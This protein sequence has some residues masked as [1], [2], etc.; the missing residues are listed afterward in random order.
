RDKDISGLCEI[1]APLAGRIVL[2][3]VKSERTALP[4]DL[5]A[6]CRRG[7]PSAALEA[8]S[9]LAEALGRVADESLILI[10][11]SLYLVGEAMELLKLS[12]TP[13]RDERQLNEWGGVP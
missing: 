8:V 10:T 3:P 12:P 11:G 7:N 6:T 5:M 13:S 1:L 2:S 9:S 4:E